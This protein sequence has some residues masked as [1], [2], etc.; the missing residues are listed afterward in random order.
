MSVLPLS[1]MIVRNP[2][3]SVDHLEYLVDALNQQS[4]QQTE[5][6][7]NTFW[8][9]QSDSPEQLEQLLSGHATFPWL[10]VPVSSPVVAGVVCWEL[11]SVFAALLEHPEMGETFT[12]L[13]MECLPEQ[14][15]IASLL[16]LLPELKARFGISYVAM[17]EQLW[18]NLSVKD[19]FSGVYW[20]QLRFSDLR[21]WTVT[22][23]NYQ[24]VRHPP[25]TWHKV[26]SWMENAFV[27][28]SALAR[29]TGLFSVVERPLYFQD[30]FDIFT[31]VQ[32]RPYW[33]G[34]NL[35]KLPGSLVYHLQHPRPFLEFSKAFVEAIPQHPEFF[36]GLAIYG[37][38]W[39]DEDYAETE[40]MRREFIYTDRLHLFYHLFRH[41][42]DGANDHWLRALDKRFGY[43]HNQP[44]ESLF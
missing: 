35:L 21:Y 15:F 18:T 5:S 40:T 6:A 19:L 25:Y 43:V 38:K 12:Y 44:F 2:F 4:G 42:P 10:H 20:D 3:L 32:D 41:A 11:T 29:E 14:D 31:Y 37:F 24:P 1:L 7:Y 39:G 28:P 36:K 17:L 33:R 26:P 30:V 23:M 34:I 22:H 8:I 13:H 27:M 9:D 16:D